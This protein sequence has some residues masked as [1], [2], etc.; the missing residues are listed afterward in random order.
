LESCASPK[1]EGEM[2]DSA[3]NHAIRC[4][5]GLASHKASIL[6]LELERMFRRAGGRP[7]RQPSTRNLLGKVFDHAEL[8][9]LFPGGLS[10][11]ASKIREGF[12]MEYLTALHG[13]PGRERD[14]RVTRIKSLSPPPQPVM[15]AASFASTCVFRGPNL[16][17][18]HGN[19][20][21]TMP[22]SM[23]PLPPIKP[24]FC[25]IYV[26]AANLRSPIRSR[27]QKGTRRVDLGDS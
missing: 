22:L 4:H 16:P 24:Q 5:H 8:A 1:C 7:D 3:G 10:Q 23:R 12:A 2:L 26:Q 11:A 6:E 17:M 9:A 21:S 15:Q 14:E 20:G 13:K 27:K 25:D 18:R 19:S